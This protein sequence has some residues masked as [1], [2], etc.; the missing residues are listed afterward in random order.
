L[1]WL[2]DQSLDGPINCCATNPISLKALMTLVESATGK[3]SRIAATPASG[4]SSPFGIEGDWFMS[5]ERLEAC[6]FRA[7]PLTA[8]LPKLVEHFAHL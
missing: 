4:S 1:D 8:W 5:T 6:G 2:S 7:E 3:S